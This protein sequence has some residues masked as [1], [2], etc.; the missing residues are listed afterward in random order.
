MTEILLRL[1]SVMELTGLSKS[2]LYDLQRQ[3]KFPPA[4]RLTRRCVAW[5]STEVQA[6][7]ASRDLAKQRGA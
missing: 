3:H 4:R 2:T 5:V 1:P 7:I 6:W